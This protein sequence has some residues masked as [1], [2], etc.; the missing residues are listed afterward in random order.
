MATSNRGRL[1]QRG[2]AL[3][4]RGLFDLI[5]KLLAELHRQNSLIADIAQHLAVLHVC[6][7]SRRDQ[8]INVVNG[9][10][11]NELCDFSVRRPLK[12]QAIELRRQNMG[13]Q[14][15]STHAFEPGQDSLPL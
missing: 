2:G 9:P 5:S 12:R 7:G 6:F 3:P 13:R 10:V 15:T 4:N 11:R 14:M 8:Q 1:P